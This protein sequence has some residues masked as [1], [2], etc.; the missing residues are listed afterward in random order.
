M[1]APALAVLIATCLALS[2]TAVVVERFTCQKPVYE[3]EKWADD[4][5]ASSHNCYQYSMNEPHRGVPGKLQ[6]GQLVGLP[7]LTEDKY[8][9]SE[10]VRRVKADRPGLID[11]DADPQTVC[12]CNYYK[13]ALFL[14]PQK[15]H[16]YH[17]LRQ[18]DTGLWSHKPGELPVT[19]VDADGKTIFDPLSANRTY[20]VAGE[21][22]FDYSETCAFFCVPYQD[23]WSEA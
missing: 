7:P 12:P 6:P 20:P 19:N 5:E 22:P 4:S 13:V 3:P 8:S 21:P 10:F 9:C 17:F 14:S 1:D 2:M 16:D 23:G 15:Q 11:S 18:D